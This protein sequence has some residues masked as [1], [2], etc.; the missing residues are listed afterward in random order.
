MKPD[1]ILVTQLVIAPVSR[2]H[3]LVDVERWVG[4]K[5]EPNKPD[6]DKRDQPKLNNFRAVLRVAAFSDTKPHAKKLVSNVR[7]SFNDS[8]NHAIY[9][10]DRWFVPKKDVIER[11]NRAAGLL[12]YPGELNS[13]E[14]A[15]FSAWPIGSPAIPGLTV[16][17]TRYLPPNE[18]IAREGRKLGNSVYESFRN[19]PVAMTEEGGTRHVYAIGPSGRGKS[20]LLNNMAQQDI[21]A[22]HGVIVID[23]KGDQFYP[24]L[25]AIPRE[26][27]NDVIVLDFTDSEHPVGFN[28]LREGVVDDIYSMFL[29]SSPDSVYLKTVLHHALHAFSYFPELT[30]I[31]VLPFV[32]AQTSIEKA[33]RDGL[34][35]RMPKSSVYRQYWQSFFSRTDKEQRERVKPLVDRV[36]ELTSRRDPRNFLGQSES[37]FNMKDVLV[38]NKI[39]L[40]Y[41]PENLGTPTI[42]LIGS[43]L[44]GNIWSSVRAVR[45]E[46]TKPTYLYMDEVQKFLNLPIDLPDMLSL[47]RSY[48][49]GLVAAHQYIDQLPR[50]LYSAIT[51]ASTKIAF[52]L[53]GPDAGRL[54][55]LFGK[56]VTADDFMALDPF[57]ALVKV[58]TPGGSSEPTVIKTYPPF[59]PH[60]LT[61]QVRAASR[62]RYSRKASDV[63]AEIL[64]RRTP[65]SKSEQKRERTFG[66]RLKES[67]GE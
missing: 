25:D 61:E 40:I 43:L 22:G 7:A 50:E 62:A 56:S 21:E 58:A 30:V 34:V 16:G 57:Q 19:R 35:E 1:D 52:K 31:D 9:F 10:T 54:Q 45:G 23:A 2:P 3:G 59:K 67:G 32:D 27:V 20:A 29:H 24:L 14:L 13:L 48:Q 53:D 41:L 44:V 18:T 55:T 8:A 64:R 11:L 60:G 5:R 47:A 33:W 51:N 26:R 4:F 65:P 28:I 36:W 63:D 15:T 17:K 12:L 39:M 46:K 37:T 6:P 49:L 42:S 66:S 38:N